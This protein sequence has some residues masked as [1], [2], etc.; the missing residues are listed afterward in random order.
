LVWHKRFLN[1]EKRVLLMKPLNALIV[2]YYWPPSGGVAV[3]RWLKFCKYLPSEGIQ[4]IVYAPSNADY[5]T[6]DPLLNQQVSKDITVL[7][8]PILEPNSW[9][10]KLTGKKDTNFGN[11]VF[12]DKGSWFKRQALKLRSNRFIPD[13]RMLWIKPSIR[14]LSNYIQENEI[15]VLIT[16]GTPHSCHVIGLEL[17]KKFPNLPWLADFRDPW[18][19]IDYFHEL[20]LSARALTKHKKLEHSVVSSADAITTVSPS[21]GKLFEEKGAKKVGVITNGYDPVDFEGIAEDTKP[22]TICIRHLGTLDESRNPQIL[23]EVLTELAE[24][25]SDL[26]EQLSIELIGHVAQSIIERVQKLPVNIKVV[27]PIAH[28]EALKRMSSSSML[29][30]LNNAT[31]SNRGRIPAK[32]FEYAAAK[33]PILY[34][35]PKENDAAE[36]IQQQQLGQVFGWTDKKALRQYIQDILE[37]GAPAGL[38]QKNLQTFTRPYQAKQMTKMIQELVRK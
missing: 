22:D 38:E 2:T 28:A 5:P 8:R 35:G 15:D 31:G 17:K 13:S 3:M 12:E 20:D 30:L 29:L 16:N 6:T 14:F 21:W 4:P 10:K 34:I 32:L 26:S 1:A 25:N 33:S 18:L 7:R 9:F 19:E 27:P 11:Q 37:N 36:L 23:W 24:A